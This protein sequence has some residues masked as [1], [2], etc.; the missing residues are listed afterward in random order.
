MVKRL[1]L[2]AAALLIGTSA[3]ASCPPTNVTPIYGEIPLRASDGPRETARLVEPYLRM[4]QSLDGSEVPSGWQRGPTS[5][6]LGIPA[7]TG[8]RAYTFVACATPTVVVVIDHIDPS[9]VDDLL[10]GVYRRSNGGRGLYAPQMVE[11][12]MDLYPGHWVTVVGHSGG[13]G[14]TS[15]VAGL[16]GLPSITFNAP[17]TDASL[18]NP[19]T[20]QINVVVAGD[21]IAN[22]GGD[23]RAIPGR[24]LTLDV[25]GE[26]RAY[27]HGLE[28][29]E[30]GL[31]ALVD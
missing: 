3:Q 25:P 30:I 2:L 16:F 21:P 5:Q 27:L 6:D 24:T 17:R 12:V 7:T 22:R 18:S 4:V 1:T 28:A 10:A 29:L 14:Q 23:D 26:G 20:R 8:F 19:G 15:W 9:K 13:G 31:A 11:M